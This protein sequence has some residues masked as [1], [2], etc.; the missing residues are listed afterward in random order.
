MPR[1]RFWPTPADAASIARSIAP[2]RRTPR[3]PPSAPSR[4]AGRVVLTGIHSDAM[5]PFEVS[6]MRRK[7]LAILNVRRSN[8]ESHDALELLTARLAWFA[9]L[10]HTPA[11]AV[12]YR[13]RLHAH[14]AL[15]RRCRQ[16]GDHPIA[17]CAAA[18]RSAAAFSRERRADIPRHPGWAH[19]SGCAPTEGRLWLALPAFA[20]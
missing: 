13:R 17:L 2:P 14:R 7:E 15:R 19:P 5:V 12:R 8:H 4:N 9:P 16:N 1:V 6:P 3:T 10:V 11:P 20:T 18:I